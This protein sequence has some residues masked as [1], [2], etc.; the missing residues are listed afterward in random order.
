MDNYTL[1]KCSVCGFAKIYPTPTEQELQ[2]L[3]SSVDK[4]IAKGNVITVINSFN[5]KPG[6]VIK[7]LMPMRI[8]PVLRFLP[9]INKSSAI[10]DVGCGSGIYLATMQKL[11]FTN[12]YGMEYNTDSVEEINNR[13]K[14]NKVVVNPVARHAEIPKVDLITAFDVIEH[15]PDPSQA[16][17]EM[18]RMLNSGGCIHVRMPNYGSF[19]AKVLRTKWLWAIP[20]Y[21]LNYFN[22]KSLHKMAVDNGFKVIKLRSRRSGYR[23]A[24]FALQ[25][26]KMTSGNIDNNYSDALSDFKFFIVN[27]AEF[28]VRVIYSPVSLLCGLFNADDCLEL[29]AVKTAER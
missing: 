4:N 7:A 11:G 8:T 16:F 1:Y 25:L 20:P 6:Q 3:Y 5:N 24:F 9:S 19:W 22:Y 29:Y 18:N 12:L 17:T 27:V 21:H 10:L 28:M 26:K 14:F 13:F 23:M 2:A 15:V